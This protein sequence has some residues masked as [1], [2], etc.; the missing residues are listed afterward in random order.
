MRVVVIGAGISGIA[1]ARQLAAAGHDVRVLD[2]GRVPGGRL[3]SRRMHGRVVDLGASYFTV[4][5]ASGFAAVVAD[6]QARGLARPWTDTFAALAG[7]GSRQ[8]KPG[9]VRWAAPAGLRSLVTDLAADLV[10]E[11]EHPVAAVG[12]GP[13]VDGAAY[14]AAVLAMPDPQALRLLDPACPAAALVTGREWEPC[15]ALAAGFDRREW[16]VDG[17]FVADDP[18]LS[19]VADDGSRRGD[20]APVL[21]GHST[22]AFAARHLDAPD[23]AAPALVASLRDLLGLPEP[24]WSYVQRWRFA[25]PVGTRDAAYGVAGG[26]GLCGD[27][28][29][30]SK[31]Q[32]A[33]ESGDALGRALAWTSG[34][35]AGAPQDP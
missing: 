31:V 2:R 28:W 35:P 7:D 24:A 30:R 18:V 34:G 14:D 29:G 23:E 1:C 20:G 6:W 15:L 8:D 5:P 11:Q 21:V 10:V 9:P 12:P 3:A 25:K 26:I 32:A 27:G 4:D 33:W 17:A 22:P 19:W 13:T 16:A